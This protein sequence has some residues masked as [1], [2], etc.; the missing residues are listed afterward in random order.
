MLGSDTAALFRRRAVQ[1]PDVL[2]QELDGELVFL[3]LRTESYFSLDRTGSEMF[4]AL[5]D[6]PTIEVAY[7][8]LRDRYAASPEAMQ[9]DLRTLI[10]RCMV[11]GLLEL[12]G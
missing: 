9:R 7:D 6:G 2:S 12:D 8:R 10:E 1:P 4:R 11:Q 5:I 3:N